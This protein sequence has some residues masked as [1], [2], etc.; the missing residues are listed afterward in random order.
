MRHQKRQHVYKAGQF[1]ANK[2]VKIEKSAGMHFRVEN[3]ETHL[4]ECIY[5]QGYKKCVHRCLLLF[6]QQS[7]ALNGLR[8]G[9]G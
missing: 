8:R 2:V 4:R 9:L 5:V 1:V 7:L 6:V 3:I